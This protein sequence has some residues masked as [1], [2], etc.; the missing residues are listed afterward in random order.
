MVILN[1]LSIILKPKLKKIIELQF[2][3]SIQQEKLK[4]KV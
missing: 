3:I 2:Q 1:I 4:L